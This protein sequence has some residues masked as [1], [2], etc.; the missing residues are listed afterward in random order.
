MRK[1]QVCKTAVHRTPE[2]AE[3]YGQG[4]AELRLRGRVRVGER[5]EKVTLPPPRFTT[6]LPHSSCHLHFDLA[7][8]IAL[9]L[10]PRTPRR[11]LA[12][13]VVP[14]HGKAARRSRIV[15]AWMSYSHIGAPSHVT[16]ATASTVR[17]RSYVQG[18]LFNARSACCSEQ[19]IRSVHRTSRER[20]SI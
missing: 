9:V 5:S 12:V 1:R 17:R 2:P 6:A 16:L 19:Q 20:F 11:Q 15:R 4:S 7:L 14:I 3:F 18:I 8:N 10:L 13:L